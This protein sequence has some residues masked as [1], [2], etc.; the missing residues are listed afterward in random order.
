MGTSEAKIF[1]N[2][3]A[4]NVS[5]T[6]YPPLCLDE[7][8]GLG[9]ILVNDFYRGEIKKNLFAPALCTIKM[10]MKRHVVF[11]GSAISNFELE[12]LGH[13]LPEG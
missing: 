7:K 9:H 11:Q 13:V 2:S 8:K 6:S 3:L 4:D 1:W 12:T 5:Q 10:N